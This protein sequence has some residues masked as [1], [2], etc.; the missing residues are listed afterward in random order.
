MKF[1]D[2]YKKLI[3]SKEYQKFTKENK[4]AY[5]C[6]GLFIIDRQKPQIEV[7]FDYYLPDTKKIFSFKIDK[8]VD[9]VPLENVDPTI[10]E[11]LGMNYSFDLATYEK[12]ILD[13]MTEEKING[14]L[15]KILFSL[16]KT[17]G[18]DYLVTTCF[19]SNLGLLKVQ[20]DIQQN[21][22]ILF[23]KKSFFDMIRVIKGNKKE[24]KEK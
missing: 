3:D 6:S 16:Q 18:K 20:I 14:N 12:L 21:K 1:Q 15:Q 17:K 10:P 11:K 2:Y 5:P 8:Q 9:L 19:L 7:T 23:E 13:R 4:K 24:E 22:I